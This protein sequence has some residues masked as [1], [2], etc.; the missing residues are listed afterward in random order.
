MSISRIAIVLGIVLTLC[1]AAGAALALYAP[2]S[3]PAADIPRRAPADKQVKEDTVP[4]V[5][6]ALV[7]QSDLIVVATTPWEVKPGFE[8]SQTLKGPVYDN[9]IYQV[10]PIPG[11]EALPAEHIGRKWVLFL[12]A[13]ERDAAQPVLYPA[14]PQG[15]F[16]PYREELIRHVQAALP[17]PE[18]WGQVRNRLRL[19]LHLRQ[20]R[21][22]LGDD[23]VA[24]VHLQNVGRTDLPV[25]QLHYNIYDFWRDTRF[26]VTGPSGKRWVLEKPVGKMQEADFPLRRVLRPGESYIHTVRLNH[27]PATGGGIQK[28]AANLFVEPGTYTVR[29]VYE[30][31][32]AKGDPW[33]VTSGPVTLEL[34]RDRF[35]E[36]RA[37]DARAYLDSCRFHIALQPD[38]PEGKWNAA[39]Q[40][41]Y[42][43]LDVPAVRYEP[44]ANGPNGKPIGAHTRI[45]KEEAGRIV[46]ALVRDGYFD[47]ALTPLAVGPD[48]KG[49]WAEIALSHSGSNPPTQY[50]LVL[51][52]GRPTL[53]RL[54]ALRRCVDGE[55]GQLLD[56][57]LQPLREES[58]G[59]K[60]GDGKGT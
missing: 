28:F 27:W 16:R 9:R 20:T 6:R 7:A 31:G 32:L 22:R 29:C 44:E 59:W 15:W 49:R 30:Y 17:Q 24:E 50:R 8:V 41:R 25:L 37:A 51:P 39:Y 55:A 53:H 23:V 1:G 35:G 46:D 36:L 12:R 57:L 5:L 13:D 47:R 2:S 18:A 48:V 14:S 58:K 34:S 4:P 52:W 19:G 45:P 38:E 11:M 42:V 21:F 40:L 10:A 43:A 33:S 3:E 26:E 56:R 54:E 60:D